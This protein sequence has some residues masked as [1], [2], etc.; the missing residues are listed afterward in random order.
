MTLNASLTPS[1]N[2]DLSNW[3]LTLPVDSSGGTGGTAV[4]IKSLAGYSSAYFYTGSYG[5]M[6]FRAAVDGATTS[7]SNYARSELREMK[8]TERAA[9]NLTTGGVMTATLEVDAAPTRFDGTI[10]KVV[11]GQIHGQSDELVRLY[12]DN[13]KVYFVNDQAGSSNSETKFYFTNSAGFQP[14]VSLNERFSYTIDAKGSTLE[15]SLYADGDVYRS[16]TP[17]NSVWQSD[18][19]YFKAG[20]YLGVNE[21]QGTGYGQT[22][23][24]DLRF[25]HTDTALYPPSLSTVAPVEDTASTG[26]TA[27][28]GS[29]TTTGSD[30][31]VLPATTNT[32]SGSM[33]NN[34]VK[35]TAANDLMK[36]LAGRDV[37]W[38]NAGSDIMW[39]GDDRDADG[40]VFNTAI[41]SDVDVIMDFKPVDDYVRLENAIFTKLTK[42]GVLSASNFAL[43]AAQDSNDYIVYDQ[44]SGNLSYDADG[45]GAGSAVVFAHFYNQA[46][47]TAADLIVI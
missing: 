1:G 11:V 45:S 17:I 38:G 12:W 10:G 21:T 25:N 7:G 29:T 40:F 13:S 4:E 33:S 30:S 14:N 39:G 41:G 24:Y 15:V 37:F 16:V 35:G 34:Y 6:V 26:T 36:G 44:A 19:F 43:G 5:A 22:S 46:A 32:V 27:P 9:W 18:Q 3:K 28:A 20:V 2:F 31:F 42:T 8:G 23:F 47:V